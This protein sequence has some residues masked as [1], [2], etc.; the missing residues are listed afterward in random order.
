MQGNCFSSINPKAFLVMVD[1]YAGQVLEDA[2]DGSGD[3][4]IQGDL[5]YERA[6]K[7]AAEDEKAF[8]KREAVS[9]HVL[10]GKI[11]SNMVHSGREAAAMHIKQAIDARMYVPTPV[12]N[13]R[14]GKRADDGHESPRQ[15][16]RA[17]LEREGL[18]DAL[19]DAAISLI[20]TFLCDAVPQIERHGFSVSDGA[21]ATIFDASGSL[22]LP[23]KARRAVDAAVDAR[24]RGGM[25][26]EVAASLACHI[27]TPTTIAAMA[28]D[29]AKLGIRDYKAPVSM[30]QGNW[31]ITPHRDINPQTG[32][33]TESVG[34]TIVIMP[35][36]SYAQRNA[37]MQAVKNLPLEFVVRT[38]ND[39]ESEA[40]RKA[41]E[42]IVDLRHA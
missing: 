42:A 10:R 39:E 22:Q 26:K 40:A 28:E 27:N 6:V 35:D 2:E 38:R 30:I 34:A 4:E 25:T 13:S 19:G 29:L 31:T 3:L 8:E 23:A 9:M 11:I 37:V 41:L 7:Q 33:I 14:V 15:A 21:V 1:T 18:L 5:D 32:E 36:G 16:M 24:R 17:L 20:L 12:S